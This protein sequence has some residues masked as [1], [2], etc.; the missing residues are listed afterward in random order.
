MFKGRAMVVSVR[1]KKSPTGWASIREMI[2]PAS[3]SATSTS[4]CVHMVGHTEG[5]WMP[6]YRD[7]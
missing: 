7:E 4:H 2:Q 5:I 3:D 1:Y 6:P